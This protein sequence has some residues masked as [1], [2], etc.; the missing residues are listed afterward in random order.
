MASEAA[1]RYRDVISRRRFIELTGVSGAAAL[2]GCGQDGSTN[3]TTEGSGGSDDS[4]GS[5]DTDSSDDSGSSDGVE[6]LDRTLVAATNVGVP[7]NLHYNPHNTQKWADWSGEMVFDTFA[8]YHFGTGEFIMYAISEWDVKPTAA[9]LTL[10]EGLTWH[11]GDPVTAK[12][13]ETQFKIG[14]KTGNPLWDFTERIE[15]TGDRTIELS[16]AS[17]TNPIV[18][19]H[20]LAE[21][22][23]DTKHSV[24]KQFL[25]KDAS[26]VQSFKYTEN[27][28]GTGP[29][30]Y[31]GGADKQSLTLERY[32]DHPDASNINFKRYQY[33]HMPDNSQM[34]AGLLGGQ[35]DAV[36]SLFTPPKVVANLPEAVNEARVPAK[37]GYGL[38]PNHEDELF[39]QREV[40]QAIM[41]VINREQVRDNAGP[42]TKSTPTVPSGIAVGDQERWLGDEIDTYETYGQGETQAKKATELLESAGFRKQDGSWETET[43]KTVKI[44]IKQFAG[45]GDWVTASQTIAD[46]LSSFGFDASVSTVPTGQM[47]G[48][49]IEGDFRLATGFWLPGGP[50]S[51]FPFYP[52]RHQIKLTPWQRGHSYP[53]GEIEVPS[54]SGSG[55]T[56]FDPLAEIEKIPSATDEAAATELV[57]KAAWHNNQDLPMLSL[58]EKRE[59]SFVT[60]DEW[61]VPEDGHEKYKVKWPCHWLPRQG[62]LQAT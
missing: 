6:V 41:H 56:S 59:Q 51:A 28:L 32:P 31:N 12:D 3:T 33:V 4:S 62:D 23:V 53:E 1:D 10:R 16:F 2:A 22:R 8:Q 15:V 27:V 35:L 7:K 50:R 11:N 49:L 40:R 19:K 13:L 20:T 14:K 46:Q 30:R 5:S 47:W 58:L 26:E 18:V 45:W 36:M 38:L 21:M 29:F 55:T 42:R 34:H 43:G 60:E 44:P 52:L 39:G 17:E 37:W 61:A 48:Q 54:R 25:D 9:T 57:R 24:Y